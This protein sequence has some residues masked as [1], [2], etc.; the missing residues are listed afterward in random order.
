MENFA[1]LLI[2]GIV[3]IA[4]AAA[5]AYFTT[6]I[7]FRAEQ[8]KDSEDWRANILEN[9]GKNYVE[10]QKIAQQF[11]IG[12]IFVEDH[13]KHQKTFIPKNFNLTIGR[14]DFNDICSTHI[15]VSRLHCLLSSDDRDVYIEDLFPTNKTQINGNDLIVRTKLNDNDKITIGEVVM[16]FKKVHGWIS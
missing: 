12:L 2:G 5:T 15:T 6:Q 16:K 9:Y 3:S 1:F 11:A 8:K 13:E 14:S 7:K 10:F 4:V